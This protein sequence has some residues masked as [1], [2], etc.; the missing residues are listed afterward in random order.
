MLLYTRECSSVLDD[1][2]SVLVRAVVTD[3]VRE[4]RVQL[5]LRRKVPVVDLR[6]LRLGRIR[7]ARREGALQLHSE[8]EEHK[9]AED[10]VAEREQAVPQN[11]LEHVL[12]ARCAGVLAA[13]VRLVN[14]VAQRLQPE[15]V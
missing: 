2:P 10:G 15:R 1:F 12:H 8:C 5:R 3:R 11:P 6:E 13:R 9:E 14:H 4:Q 7:R